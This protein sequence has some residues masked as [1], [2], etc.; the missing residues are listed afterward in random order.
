M[1]YRRG[2]VVRLEVDGQ[3]TYNNI[4]RLFIVEDAKVFLLS[5]IQTV[6]ER[7]IMAYKV[8][9]EEKRMLCLYSSFA[10]PGVL[11][12]K[13]KNGQAYIVEKDSADFD[14]CS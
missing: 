2:A 7:H 12:V 14:W 13:H 5:Q 6:F 11:H 1:T 3:I 4:Q 8:T 9:R 10:R